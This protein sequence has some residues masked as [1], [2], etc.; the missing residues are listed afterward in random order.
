M[1]RRVEDLSVE[2]Q[3]ERARVDLDRTVLR[4]PYA[5]RVLSTSADVGQFVNAGTRRLIV[6]EEGAG[7][8]GQSASATPIILPPAP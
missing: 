7:C 8:C 3:L 2:A 6:R 5:G 1:G 4:A